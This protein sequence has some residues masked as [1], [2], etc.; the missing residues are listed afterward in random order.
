MSLKEKKQK[1]SSFAVFSLLKRAVRLQIYTKLMSQHWSP[2]VI[3]QVQSDHCIQQQRRHRKCASRRTAVSKSSRFLADDVTRARVACL[4]K[5]MAARNPNGRKPNKRVQCNGA[6]G[7][8]TPNKDLAHSVTPKTSAIPQS[9]STPPGWP[10]RPAQILSIIKQTGHEAPTGGQSSWYEVV[11]GG[12]M[13]RQ[14]CAWWYEQGKGSWF[15]GRP[16]C[17]YIALEV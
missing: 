12:W 4:E 10:W 2:H 17:V 8:K 9:L 7:D 5:N 13:C 11:G 16:S 14:C 15:E 3:V 6:F 1:I